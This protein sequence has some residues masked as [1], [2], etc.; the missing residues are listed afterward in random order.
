MCNLLTTHHFLVVMKLW[1]VWAI[2]ENTWSLFLPESESELGDGS[3][4][5]GDPSSPSRSLMMPVFSSLVAAASLTKD[6]FYLFIFLYILSMQLN[7]T[8]KISASKWTQK[9]HKCSYVSIKGLV[10]SPQCHLRCSW[11]LFFSWKNIKGV[12]DLRFHFLNVS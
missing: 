10:Y 6:G 1:D 9:H 2:D 8:H 11:L 3:G 5:E 12:V 4:S 7:W